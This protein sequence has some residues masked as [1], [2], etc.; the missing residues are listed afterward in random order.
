MS[1]WVRRRS[2]ARAVSGGNLDQDFDAALVDFER[3]AFDAE[4]R[5]AAVEI[6][7]VPAADFVRRVLRYSRDGHS[8]GPR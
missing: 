5:R 3:A 8:S 1:G 4:Y 6:G 2:G 7:F